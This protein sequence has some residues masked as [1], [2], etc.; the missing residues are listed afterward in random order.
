MTIGIGVL[1]GDGIV[2]GADTQVT[3]PGV[4]KVYERKLFCHD[5]SAR[6]TAVLAFCGSVDFMRSFNERFADEM[7]LAEQNDSVLSASLRDG[8]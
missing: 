6:W 7:Q 2:L 8:S 1:C 4:Y 5:D 3:L